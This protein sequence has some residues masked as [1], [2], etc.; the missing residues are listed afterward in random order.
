MRTAI[1]GLIALVVGCGDVTNPVPLVLAP[2]NVTLAPRAGEAFT[3]TGGVS[4]YTWSN[5]SGGTINAATGAYVAGT[6]PSLTDT[7]TVT[8]A[9]GDTA[10]AT[11]TIGAGITITPATA[12][13]PAG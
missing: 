3:A 11:V 10:T 4:P 9:S 8:D 13:S 12:I 2:G 7:V 6:A 1:V 5:V